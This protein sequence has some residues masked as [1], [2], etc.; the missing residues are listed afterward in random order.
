[1]LCTSAG[2]ELKSFKYSLSAAARRAG[3]THE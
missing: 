3:E 2:G 1:V